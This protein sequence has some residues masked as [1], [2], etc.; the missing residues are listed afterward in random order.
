MQWLAPYK[1]KI[2][3][4]KTN[5]GWIFR[6]PFQFPDGEMDVYSSKFYKNK[7]TAHRMALQ[8]RRELKN[9]K[10]LAF[11]CERLNHKEQ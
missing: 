10:S 5:K 7:H 11:L 2:E 1:D 4:V 8:I 9:H 3:T 6:F